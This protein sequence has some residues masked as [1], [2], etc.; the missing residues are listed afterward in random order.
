MQGV[1]DGGFIREFSLGDAHPWPVSARA[2]SKVSRGIVASLWGGCGSAWMLS[3]SSIEYEK[4]PSQ[5]HSCYESGSG[6]L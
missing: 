3:V 4:G 1:M 5:P 2:S 6:S